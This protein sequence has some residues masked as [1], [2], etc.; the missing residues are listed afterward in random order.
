MKL[1]SL[2]GLFSTLI[3]VT[4]GA[5][6]Q[7]PGTPQPVGRQSM[8]LT[9]QEKS[10]MQNTVLSDGR[11]QQVMGA[12][13]SRVIVSEA[14]VDKTEA[15]AFMRGETEKPPTHRVHVL[16]FN[17][18]TNRATHAF[19]ALEQNTVLSV[20]A[21]DPS[22]VPLFPEDA[23]DAL[24][25]AKA[26]PEVRRAVGGSLDQFVILESGSSAS[27]PFAAQAMRL[28]SADPHDPCAAD[29]CLALIFRTAEGYLSL[30]VEVN[31]NRHTVAVISQ[32]K[33]KHP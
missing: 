33:G 29:R 6:A 19:V 5:W 32:Q 8:T 14:Q 22:Q 10:L 9:A 13:Q 31:L 28:R 18:K 23:A 12:G 7:S 3:L 20:E 30:R 27:P 21:L 11:V 26:S 1:H 2:R 16:V 4:S 25:L 15:L 17:P 24:A